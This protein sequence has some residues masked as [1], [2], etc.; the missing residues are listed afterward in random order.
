MISQFY[1][2]A[3][4]TSKPTLDTLLDH[5][6]V[7]KY[8]GEP[9]SDE[10]LAAILDAGRAV[11]TSS[12]LQAASIIRVNDPAKRTALRQISNNLSAEKY[13]ELL[14]RGKRLGHDYVES[15]AKYLIFCVDAHRHAVLAPQAELDWTEVL[16]IGAIDAA[17][18]AQN[19]LAAAESL[20]LGGVFIGSVRN[21]I[22]RASE[23]LGLPK[24]VI[25]LFGLCLG[26]PDH[27]APINQGRRPRLPIDVLVSTD[28][29]HEASADELEGFNQA[30]KEYYAARG[31]EMD[32]CDQ[33]QATFGHPVRP[34]MLAYL[35][36]QGFAKR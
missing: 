15:C 13:D 28:T 33:I 23:I 17:L 27:E 30:V 8:T 10:M 1:P 7:R 19:V 35:N 5:R 11:S 4:L 2:N 36:A 21:D 16:L 6:S 18:F 20:G 3:T 29:Y 31:K 34:H 26:H 25:P 22:A 14:A 12:Y 9:I 24:H 32:W